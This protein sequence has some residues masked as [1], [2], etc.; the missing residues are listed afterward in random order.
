MKLRKVLMFNTT[1]G[2]TLPGEFTN[3]LGLS[4]GDY[5]EV[6]LRDRKAIVVKRHGV[7]PKKITVDD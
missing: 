2:L 6:Y 4:R 5:V 3:A 7:Q 1:L